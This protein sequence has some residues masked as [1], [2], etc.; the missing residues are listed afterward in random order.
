MPYMYCNYTS[1]VTLH[2][3]IP[4][5]FITQ[6]VTRQSKKSAIELMQEKFETKAKL[7]KEELEVRREELELQKRK[8]ELEEEERKRK[9][10]LEQQ[11]RKAILSLLLKHL[12]NEQ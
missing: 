12:G 7:K 9:F 2:N 8:L 5:F 1:T 3:V 6:L 4:F 10:E 11:E